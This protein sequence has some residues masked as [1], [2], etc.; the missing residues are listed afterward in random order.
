MPKGTENTSMKKQNTNEKFKSL[1]G[2]QAL[3]EGVMMKGPALAAMACRLPDGEIDVE[4]WPVRGGKN[5]PWYKK[6]P[7]AR[8][9]VVFVTSLIE[10]YRCMMKAAAKQGMEEEEP[11]AFEKKL[12]KIFGGQL[13]NLVMGIGMCLGIAV[14]VGLFLYLPM[15]ITKLLAG[16]LASSF[17]KA[18]IE[19]CVKIAIFVGYMA[20]IARM[21]DIKRM[22][23]YH[24]AEHKTIACY[25]ARLPLTTENIQKQSRFHPRCGTSFMIITLI[26][27]IL[28]FSVVTWETLWMRIIL[29]ILLLPL[30]CGIAY[31]LIRLAGRYDNPVTRAVSAPGLALQR[32]TTREP[33][34]KQIACAVAALQPCIPED[35]EEDQW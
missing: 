4:T 29:K 21:P 6:I 9:S 12:Q 23:E 8:G 33:D 32:L 27:S 26:V 18:L 20:V 24:G 10:G 34:E 25:E 31:E 30:V 13:M 14:S 11:S 17:L 22:Y 5:A 7:L 1:I 2:G 15:L 35:R 28:V 16:V 3:I 19:G